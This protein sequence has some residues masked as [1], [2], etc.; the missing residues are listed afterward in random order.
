MELETQERTTAASRRHIGDQTI[1]VSAGQTLKIETSPDGIEV[2]SVDCPAGKS[3]TVHIQVTI[4][5]IDQ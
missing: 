4:N 2:L 3:W 5:E 1:E